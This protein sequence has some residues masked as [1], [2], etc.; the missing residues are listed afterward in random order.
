MHIYYITKLLYTQTLNGDGLFTYMNGWIL[1][2]NV[3]TF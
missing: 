3:D 1:V 2:V